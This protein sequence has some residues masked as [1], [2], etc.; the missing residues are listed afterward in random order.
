VIRLSIVLAAVTSAAVA[1]G[2]MLLAAGPSAAFG[3]P[4]RA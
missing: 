3:A 1:I 2:V 4:I